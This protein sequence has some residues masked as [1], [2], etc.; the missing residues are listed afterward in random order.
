MASASITTRYSPTAQIY[1]WLTVILVVGAWTLGILGDDLPRGPIRHYGELIH[2]ACGESVLFLLVLRLAL[3][4]ASA[5]PGAETH[6]SPLATY[7]AK[8]VQLCL[9]FLLFAVPAAGILTL[10]YGGEPLTIFGIYDIASPWLK[11]R[12][13]KHNAG[14]IH[15]LFANLLLSL[16]G[17]HAVAALLHHYV[18][19][20]SVL[21]RMLPAAWT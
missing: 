6:G 11:N 18:L 1:H 19:K 9:Y 5:A 20:D 2:V 16:A 15:E 14:E 3:R 10:F 13:L 21:K 12:E 8:I 7:A 4:L 17:L